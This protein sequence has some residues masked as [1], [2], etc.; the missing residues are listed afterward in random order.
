VASLGAWEAQARRLLEEHLVD[1]EGNRR[2]LTEKEARA[3]L[4]EEAADEVLR[5]LEQEAVLRAEEHQGS[6]YFEL[7]H[8]WLAKRVFEQREE[9]RQKEARAR[10]ERERE[11][12]EKKRREDERAARRRL[13][14]IAGVA[15]AV[16]VAM[17]G[18]VIWALGQRDAAQKAENEAKAAQLEA[19]QNAEQAERNAETAKKNAETAKRN[20]NEAALARDEQ[21]TQAEKHQRDLSELETRIQKASL[22]ELEK[23]RN[24][25]REKSGLSPL[26]PPRGIGG[27]VPPPP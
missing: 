26:T 21:K 9:R 10:E 8:D 24:E 15:V 11:E 25:V 3:A 22:A 12:R 23:I 16:A 4:S 7:G 5:R 2:P 17:G 19:R 20:E 27:A 14:I 1:K 13:G 6:R 18:V